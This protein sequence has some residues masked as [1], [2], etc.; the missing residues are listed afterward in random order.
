MSLSAKGSTPPQ[1]PPPAAILAILAILPTNALTLC[2]PSLSNLC[3]MDINEQGRV[4]V[5]FAIIFTCCS[6]ASSILRIY[7]SVNQKLAF[8]ADD[9]LCF[10]ALVCHVL[11]LAIVDFTHHPLGLNHCANGGLEMRRKQWP[12]KTHVDA[13]F[14]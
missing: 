12:W 7:V 13:L 5:V 3:G 11:G 1:P 9:G 14:G 8:R 10:T 6:T 2:C 4:V